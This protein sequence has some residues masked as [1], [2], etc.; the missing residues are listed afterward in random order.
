VPKRQ[1]LFGI[2]KQAA[3]NWKVLNKYFAGKIFFGN[4]RVL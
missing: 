2:L 4:M 3:K 1:N